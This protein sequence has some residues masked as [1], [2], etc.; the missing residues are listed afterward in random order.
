M[1]DN[2]KRWRQIGIPNLLQSFGYIYLVYAVLL[3]FYRASQYIG[4][5]YGEFNVEQLI[6]SIMNNAYKGL[7]LI[8]LGAVIHRLLERAPEK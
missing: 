4:G 7:L 5:P 8:G 2:K 6:T 1:R 3:G